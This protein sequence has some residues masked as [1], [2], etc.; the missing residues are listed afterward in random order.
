[1]NQDDLPPRPADNDTGFASELGRY[2]AIILG[3]GFFLALAG[4][5]LFWVMRAT[6][7]SPW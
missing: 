4:V 6:G 2:V 7:H 5:V 1:M 3:I